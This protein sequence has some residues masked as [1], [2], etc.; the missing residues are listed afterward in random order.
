MRVSCALLLGYAGSAMK[1]L[2]S[3]QV[4][5]SLVLAMLAATSIAAGQGALAEETATTSINT[6]SGSGST[7]VV[8]AA[9]LP[10]PCPAK[11][12]CKLEMG[13]AFGDPWVSAETGDANYF[14]VN[15][16]TY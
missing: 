5:S 3:Q 13:K 10:P 14:K 15:R 9:P 2:T 11:A 6:P 1:A 4:R 16:D 8:V 12:P 7:A